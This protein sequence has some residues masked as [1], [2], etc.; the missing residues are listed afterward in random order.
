MDSYICR[1]LA[2]HSYA[3]FT[4]MRVVLTGCSNSTFS[5]MSTMLDLV[6]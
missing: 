4:R 2:T 6:S 5:S 1:S 3:F